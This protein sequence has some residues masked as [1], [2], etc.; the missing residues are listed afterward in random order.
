[1]DQSPDPCAGTGESRITY[2]Q[3]E[4]VDTDA[5]EGS[6]QALA[7]KED[8]ASEEDQGEDRKEM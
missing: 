3:P 4:T 6:G 7:T 8:Q 1:M 2:G 5:I